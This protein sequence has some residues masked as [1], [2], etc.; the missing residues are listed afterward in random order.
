MPVLRLGTRSSALAMAQSGQVAKTLEARHA[1]LKV[2][3]V[4]IITRGDQLP[5]DLSKHGGKGLFTVELEQGLLDGG[6]DLAVHS[7]KDLPVNLPD[8]LAIAAY[9]KR[10]DPRD[11]LISEV[12]ASLDELADGAVVLTGS[13]RRGSQIRHRRPGVKVEPLRG[14]IDTRI[15]KW[16]DSGAAGVI[17]AAAG[18]DR[19]GLEDLPV[20]RIDPQILVPA[21]GQGTLAI[22]VKSGSRAETLCAAIQSRSSALASEAERHI[23][24]AFGGDCTLP[25]GAWARWDDEGQLR[26]TAVL[27]TPDGL[28]LARGESIGTKIEEV[29]QACLEALRADGA[30]QILKQLG[31]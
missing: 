1:D 28:S 7:L 26:L 15:R 16:R 6:L 14:N 21:P 31:R 10:A 20:H 2:E 30:D 3:L 9:P 17:L 24:R 19:L 8:G 23:V 11:V 22:E 18:L 4:P 25:L 5:G 27:G 29:A 12:A 13:L